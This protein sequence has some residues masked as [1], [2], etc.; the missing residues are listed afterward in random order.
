MKKLHLHE[1]LKFHILWHLYNHHYIG[2][3]HTPIENV[4]KGLP[5][6]EKGECLKVAKDL[7]R[8]PEQWLLP[9][10]TKH[11]LD[12]R[13]NPAKLKEILEYLEKMQRESD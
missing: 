4:A 10:P 2:R 6:D 11:G 5:K 8:S 7:L 13:L 9:Y 1:K 12:V 3:K